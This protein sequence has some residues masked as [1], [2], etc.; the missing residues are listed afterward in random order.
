VIKDLRGT[1]AILTGASRG[2]GVLIAHAL[3]D[4]GVNLALAARNAGQLEKVKGDVEARGVKAIAVATD[5]TDTAQL[6]VLVARTGAEL[7]PVDILV[8]N[9]G[10]ESIRAFEAYPEQVIVDLVATN[11]TA[12]MLLT[13][14]VLPGMLERGR[15]HIVQ[16]ASLAGKGGFAYDGP[17][18][19]SK[20]ALIMFT[21]SLRAELIDSPVGCSAICPGFVADEGMY[22]DM[23]T[24]TGVKASRLLGESKPEKVAQAVVK[25]IKRGSSELLVNPSPMRPVIVLSQMFPDIAARTLKLFGVTALGKRA[26]AAQAERDA[27]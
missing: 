16:M 11:V 20:A 6:D 23:V 10:I 19:A 25:A 4:E 8:N 3:A 14:K 21:H 1:T 22:A 18:A 26:S 17:Y 24:N 27:Q 13:R 12:P 7:G 5:V 2:L 15:G 9:A